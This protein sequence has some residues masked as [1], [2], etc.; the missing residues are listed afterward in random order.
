MLLRARG[1]ASGKFEPYSKVQLFDCLFNAV[2]RGVGVYG[3][4]LWQQKVLLTEH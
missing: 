2:G 3:N 4:V 1:L